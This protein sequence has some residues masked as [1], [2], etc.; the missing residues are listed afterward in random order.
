M[1]TISRPG[2]TDYAPYYGTYIQQV[3]DG[4]VLALLESQIEETRAL[5]SGVPES[6]WR[7]RY[8]PGKWCLTEVVGHIID[9]ERVFTHRALRFARGDNTPLPGFDENAWAPMSGYGR[10]PLPD[11]LDEF[12][13][14]RAASLAFFRGLDDAAIGRTGMANNASFT[15][16]AFPW[17]LAGHERHHTRVLRERYL[18]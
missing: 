15:V 17:I 6:R 9:V 11:I 13:V 12:G 14:V 3:P 10:R 16:R 7:H 2:P 18:T 8:A 4:D 1:P 5:L